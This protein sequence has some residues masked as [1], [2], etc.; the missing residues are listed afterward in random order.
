MW[1]RTEIKEIGRAAF[2]ANYWKSVI[3]AFLLALLAGGTMV[4]SRSQS[5]EVD[6]SPESLEQGLQGIPAEAVGFI[7]GTFL[8]IMIVA[9]LLKIFLFNPLK[10]G[11]YS[12]FR[13][14]VTD[15]ETKLDMILTGF[16]QYGRTFLTLFLTD[17]YVFLWTLL[18]I[19]PGFMKAYSYRLVPYILED[20]PELT[21]QEVLQ[22]SKE[23]MDGHRWNAF[24][25]DLSFI[26]WYILGALTFQVV[27]IFW[28]NPY[29][30]NADAALYL[31]L[32]GD[33]PNES[34]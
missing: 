23:M 28:T 19:I 7:A 13:Q 8:I 14:N 18:L 1:T 20:E 10:V 27:S 6:V 33:F 11:C 12:F 31:R 9:L 30:Q 26:G 21:P 4:S 3:A 17:L 5:T 24:V 25:Y 15:P 16:S 22:R 34:I 29:K 32:R 2:K